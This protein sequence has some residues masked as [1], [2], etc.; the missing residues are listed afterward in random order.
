MDCCAPLLLMSLFTIGGL[1][2]WSRGYDPG[3][4]I[5]ESI[6]GDWVGC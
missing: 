2:R 5:M 3:I 1:E 6:V 4:L